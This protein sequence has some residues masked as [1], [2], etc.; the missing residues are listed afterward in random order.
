MACTAAIRR[1]LEEN[2]ELYDLRKYLGA[3]REAVKD[4]VKGKMREF[5][6][7]GKA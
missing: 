4:S 5:G 1:E 7:S 6:C 2:G 3:A